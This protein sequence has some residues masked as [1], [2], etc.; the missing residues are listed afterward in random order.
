MIHLDP[1]SSKIEEAKN[2]YYKEMSKL[3]K[4]R[5]ENINKIKP[6]TGINYEIA[7]HLVYLY[8]ESN[9][10]KIL[11]GLPEELEKINDFL[12]VFIEISSDFK[13][14]IKYIFNYDWFTD[15]KKKIYNAYS[16]AKKLDV[17]TCVYCNRN[18]TNTVIT[19]KEE[20]LIRPE[21]DHFFD[22]G[23]NPLLALSFFNLIPS[24]NICNSRIKHSKEFK[25]ETHIHPY[26]DDKINEIKFTYIYDIKENNDLK[27]KVKAEN[28]ERTKRTIK[29]FAVEEVYNSHTDI[30]S[31]LLKTRKAFSDRYLDILSENLLEGINIS[32]EELYRLA[33]GVE[34]ET[35][36]FVKRPMSKFKNDILK[37]LGIID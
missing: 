23:K 35:K 30:L 27:I 7:K 25:L 1:N 2:E 22:K 5:I 26:L 8:I 19:R 21:F 31:D 37:E 24:C 11:I 29:D 15:K 28:C 17:K 33:F 6:E 12:N 34:A 4:D 32:K 20:K 18:Y 9:L 16:L 14:A 3:I 13:L 36:D 10:E